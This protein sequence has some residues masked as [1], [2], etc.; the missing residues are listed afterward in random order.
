MPFFSVI[1]PLFNKELFIEATLKSVLNQSYTDFEVIIVND[2]STDN[3]AQII[4]KFDDARIR[5]FTKDN[6]GASAARNY[7]IEKAQSNYISFIDADDYWY[8]TFL[9]EIFEKVNRF[10]DIKVFSAAIEIETSKTIFPAHYSIKKTGDFEIVNYFSAS[11]K[12][13]VICTS[14]A[15][16]NKS[17]FEDVGVF[18]TQIKSGQDTDMWI[19]IGLKYDVLFI[20]KILARYVYDENS[21]S[22]NKNYLDTKVD[23]SK[24]AENEKTNPELKKFLDLNRFSLAIKHKIAGNKSLFENCYNDI[25]L[26]KL[27]LKKRVLLLL[28]AFILK[29]LIATK[30]ALTNNG[31]GSSVFK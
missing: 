21:L 12:E 13:T 22:K 20:W 19:R 18:D 16:F 5:F 23:F 2:G 1:I 7:G 29:L 27:A 10:P 24:F 28:P 17:I 26:K 8:P 6:A 3:S 14:C 4:T 15:V 25:D 31:V 9:E 30:T 11:T